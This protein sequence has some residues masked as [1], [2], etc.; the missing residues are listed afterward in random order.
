VIGPARLHM[1]VL[2]AIAGEIDAARRADLAVRRIRVS[3]DAIPGSVMLAP[4]AAEQP[5]WREIVV[6]PA[7]V[8]ELRTEV[9][10]RGDLGTVLGVPIVR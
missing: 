9:A 5:R 1:R 3:F 2:D 6:H 7:D 4:I 8:R 10:W